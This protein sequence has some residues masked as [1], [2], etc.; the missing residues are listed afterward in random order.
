[1]FFNYILFQT[2]NV[3]MLEMG[4]LMWEI[5]MCLSCGYSSRT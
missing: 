5:L 2:C 4:I 1:V 3:K